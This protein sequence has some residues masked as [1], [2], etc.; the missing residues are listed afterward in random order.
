MFPKTFK[1][2]PL[3]LILISFIPWLLILALPFTGLDIA[4]KAIAV[5]ILAVLA[6][7]LFWVGIAIAGKDAAQRYRRYFSPKF[8]WQKFAQW[9]RDRKK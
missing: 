5:P 7:I 3:F 6:E 8:L 4:T 1:N 9:Q 2:L